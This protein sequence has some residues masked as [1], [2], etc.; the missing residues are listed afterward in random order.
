MS[1][2]QQKWVKTRVLSN[3]PGICLLWKMRW[4]QQVFRILLYL[5]SSS[6][7]R[8]WIRDHKVLHIKWIYWGFAGTLLRWH[9][10]RHTDGVGA[11][12]YQKEHLWMNACAVPC[13]ILVS[14]ACTVPTEKPVQESGWSLPKCSEGDSNSQYFG[15]EL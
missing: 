7:V 5:L 15:R 2:A 9:V 11:P 12:K 4:N 14:P 3:K 6:P 8:R 1:S 13:A 10:F